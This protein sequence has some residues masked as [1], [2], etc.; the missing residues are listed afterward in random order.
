MKIQ[1]IANDGKI[2]SDECACWEYESKKQVKEFAD[3]KELIFLTRS[4]E[5]L[6]GDIHDCAEK[7]AYIF[8]NSEE[9]LQALWGENEYLRDVR[10]PAKGY[11]YYNYKCDAW[12]NMA[13][14]FEILESELSE[15]KR[16]Y[17]RFDYFTKK[18]HN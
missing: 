13:A 17:D 15:L 18:P 8:V 1:Y 2:F 14:R 12:Q 4:G 5:I 7:A 11:W 16:I 9:A 6:F 10:P 3:K